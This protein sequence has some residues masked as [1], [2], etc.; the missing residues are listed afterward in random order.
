MRSTTE[1]HKAIIT[2]MFVACLIAGLFITGSVAAQEKNAGYR[3]IILRGAGHL[4]D[5]KAPEG[6]DAITH[7]TSEPGN[8]Y[9]F[10]KRL[11]E[12]LEKNGITTSIVD[13]TES[14]DL[15][16]VTFTDAA[17]KR[18]AADFVILAGPSYNRYL[19]KQLLALLPRLK[20]KLA[21]YPGI[22]CSSMI[23]GNYTYR[24]VD[25]MVNTD[26]SLREIGAKTV[27]GLVF[28]SDVVKQELDEDVRDFVSK[29]VGAVKEQ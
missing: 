1:K 25:T 11:A 4:P 23:S 12:E 6:P 5:A 27:P 22:V 19:P 13:Y 10:S 15:S 17:G 28:N 16:C 3:A 24:V 26:V 29:L 18:R 9:V 21:Q 7:A 20:E 14:P 2:L 8:T